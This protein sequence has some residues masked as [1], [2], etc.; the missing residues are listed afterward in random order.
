M[1]EL[2]RLIESKAINSTKL[3]DKEYSPYVLYKQS[4]EQGYPMSLYDVGIMYYTGEYGHND[5]TLAAQYFR[6][7]AEAGYVDAYYQLGKMFAMNEID[8]DETYAKCNDPQHMLAYVML[9]MY[10]TL[11][12]APRTYINN[13]I[14]S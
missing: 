1:H 11:G 7:A 5:K 13:F 4:A 12:G 8:S 3:F 6:K 10:E 2:A 9:K 14:M